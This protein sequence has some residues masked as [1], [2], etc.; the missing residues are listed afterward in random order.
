MYP[1]HRKHLLSPILVLCRLDLWQPPFRHNVVIS[2]VHSQ[3]TISFRHS[4]LGLSITSARHPSK[5]VVPA[6]HSAL[7]W[8]AP[9]EGPPHH[10]EEQPVRIPKVLAEL[11]EGLRTE[12]RMW[13]AFG[14]IQ[15][16]IMTR[17]QQTVEPLG[18]V[19][20]E[21]AGADSGGQAQE[22]LGLLQLGEGV[23]DQRVPVHYVDLLPGE[24]LQP[25]RQV[26]V[27]QAPL[28]CFVLGVDG[29]LMEQE[30][31]KGLVG[32]VAF[33]AVVED[34]GIVG[35]QPLSRVA[36]DEEQAHCWIHV[37]NPRR[38][39]RRGEVARGL[40]H[41]ELTWQGEGHLGT[42]PVQPLLIMLLHI[43]VMHL[44]K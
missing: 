24:H 26:L 1:S 38:D 40:L 39:L 41:G 29:S 43:E 16:L 12:W 4:V 37:P 34:L 15:A 9:G 19:V 22:P 31:L 28:Q 36:D 8:S 7:D 11:P 10:I 44:K 27:V 21:V 18:G 6:I 35:D 20:I 2:F 33:Q 30:L 42:V 32:L 13:P 5:I 3:S 25:V 17:V 23:P 14:L